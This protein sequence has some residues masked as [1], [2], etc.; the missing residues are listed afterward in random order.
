MNTRHGSHLVLS[1]PVQHVDA[2]T[3]SRTSKQL[4]KTA[5]ASSHGTL[6]AFGWVAA[7]ATERM[8]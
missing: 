6:G 4:R 5:R 8:M 2:R 3:A 1:C 7:R